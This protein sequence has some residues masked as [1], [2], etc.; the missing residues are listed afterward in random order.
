MAEQTQ[1]TQ[2]EAAVK[3][4][5]APRRHIGLVTSAKM[6]KTRVVLI[7]RLIQ[8]PLYKK[9]IRRDKKLYVHDEQNESGVGDRIEVEEVTRPLSKLKRYKLVRIV[10]RAK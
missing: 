4:T 8:H 10:E 2:P 1:E 5:K 7:Q 3:G 6:D 9:Y